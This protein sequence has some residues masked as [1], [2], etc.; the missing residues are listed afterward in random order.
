M[1]KLPTIPGLQLRPLDDRRL[2]IRFAYH[3]DTVA[4]I[5]TI[6]GRR[7]QPEEKC[8][9]VPH[10]HATLT[11]L[12]QLFAAAPA[13][14]SPPPS[15]PKNRVASSR[16]R[17]RQLPP[18]EEAFITPALEEM[19]LRGYSP[20]TRKS[21]RH[22][23]LS[24]RQYGNPTP[25]GTELELTI[26]Q[27]LLHLI[28]EKQVSRSYLNQSISALKFWCANVLKQPVL[29]Q[30]LPRPRPERRLPTVLSRDE[31]LRLF[32]AL[33]NPKHRMLLMLAYSS[34]LRV[35]EVVRL[36]TAD[37]DT[38]R[39]LIH[40]RRAK[41]RKDRYTPLSHVLLEALRLFW[42]PDRPPDW[43]FPGARQGKHLTTRS[44][45]KVF[46]K[47]R[48]LAGIRKPAT[49]HSLRHSYATHMLED[50]TDLRYVQQLLGHARPE[51]TMIYT[52]VMEKDIQRLRSPLD[53]IMGVNAESPQETRSR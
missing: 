6:S 19:M 16:S 15:A 10:T 24:F 42:G 9:T 38:Q 3:P 53:N 28:Q 51:S 47:A 8:W 12:R 29:I 20:A 40:I 45:Q 4:R 30:D 13:P 46:T 39:G 31:V 17:R 44:V 21:Y 49:T 37:I 25:S 33:D 23:L 7:W 26:R 32:N 52:H 34:G 50:G 2:Q 18:E 35:S 43:L 41:G 36:K 48:R 1:E 22:H 11:L 14:T 27:Y 5:K